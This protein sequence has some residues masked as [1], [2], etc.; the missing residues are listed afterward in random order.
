[1]LRFQN[2]YE[3]SKLGVVANVCDPSTLSLKQFRA[4]LKHMSLSQ[5]KWGGDGRNREAKL[6]SG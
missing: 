4:S 5:R 6:L 1:M 3:K 2:I